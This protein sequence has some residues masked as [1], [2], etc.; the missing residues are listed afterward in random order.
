MA[1]VEGGPRRHSV[2]SGLAVSVNGLGSVGFIEIARNPKELSL[3]VA[4]GY[5]TRASA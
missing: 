1:I 2:A 4:L 3:N 5:S